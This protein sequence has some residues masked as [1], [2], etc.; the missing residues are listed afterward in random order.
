MSWCRRRCAGTA[1][2]SLSLELWRGFEHPFIVTAALG[3]ADSDLV[4]LARRGETAALGVL[5]ERHRAALYGLALSIVRD[6]SV[7]RDVVQDAFLVAL[8]RLGDVR[9]PA[10]AGA[11]LRAIVRNEA[12]MRLRRFRE[13]PA[14]V[15]DDLRDPAPGPEA[16]LEALATRDWVLAA[17]ERLPQEERVTVLLRY[18]TTRPSYSEI[19]AILGI[20]VGTVRSRLNHAKRRLGEALLN[21]ATTEHPDHRALGQE[22]WREWIAAIEDME[23]R[24]DAA[25]YFDACSPDVVIDNPAAGYRTRGV[26]AERRNLENGLGIGVRLRPTGIVASRGITILEGAYE[27]PPDQPNHCPPLHTEVRLHPTG[28]TTR[29]ILHFGS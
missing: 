16:A 5:L 6:R 9:E 12:L 25:G 19:A 26:A 1:R 15:P 22:R 14:N 3:I 23:R 4:Q 20:P 8:R 13:I 18:F 7:A 2:S 27:N 24:G 11:W 29:L 28:H 17:L 10:A 21:T